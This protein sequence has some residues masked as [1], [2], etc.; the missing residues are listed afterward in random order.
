MKSS[1]SLTQTKSYSVFCNFSTVRSPSPAASSFFCN[2]FFFFSSSSMCD[3]NCEVASQLNKRR[4]M[5]CVTIPNCTSKTVLTR[6]VV[7]FC[8]CKTLTV[9][10][11][12][13][14]TKNVV[15]ITSQY[16][17]SSFKMQF[18]AIIARF[19]VCKMY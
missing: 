11:F 14:K 17:F 2:F 4:E 16:P 3:P 19:F 10:T 5:G 13:F 7:S 8:S 1:W 6:N 18:F 15:E 9:A 12:T